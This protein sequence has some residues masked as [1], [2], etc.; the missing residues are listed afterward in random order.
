[1]RG[2]LARA[3]LE[4]RAQAIEF[5]VCD[6]AGQPPISAPLGWQLS[7]GARRTLDLQ[8]AACTAASMNALREALARR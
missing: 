1:M 3:R 4:G 8:M 6:V 5:G 2:R 7:A